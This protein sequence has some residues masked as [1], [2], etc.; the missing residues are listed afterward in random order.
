MLLIAGGSG[1]LTVVAWASTP[2]IEPV[3]GRSDDAQLVML[4]FGF[5]TIFSLLAAVLLARGSV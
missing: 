5:V 2:G 3:A 4:T 1:F